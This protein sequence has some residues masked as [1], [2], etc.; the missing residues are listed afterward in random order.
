[1]DLSLNLDVIEVVSV[2]LIVG[3]DLDRTRQTFAY[4]P[5]LR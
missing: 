5:L 3:C 1:M 4:P 2:M